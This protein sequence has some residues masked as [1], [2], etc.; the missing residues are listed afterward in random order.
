M[1]DRFMN[2]LK[3]YRGALAWMSKGSGLLLIAFG[4]L[5]ITDNMTVLTAWLQRWTPEFP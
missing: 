3:R 1:I 2:L 5:M 4:L